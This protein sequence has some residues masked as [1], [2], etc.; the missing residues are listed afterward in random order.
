[1]ELSIIIVGWNVADLLSA[2]LESI[3]AHPPQAEYEIWV[4]DNASSDDTVKRVR[5]QFPQVK[6]IANAQNTGFA[7]AN[8]QAIELSQGK[9]ILLLN[10]D[11]IV[12]ERT[13]QSMLDFLESHPQAGAVGSIYFSPDGNLQKSCMP[14]P[15]VSRELW[16]LFHLDVLWS[17]GLYDMA[18]WS[19]TEPREVETLQGASLMLRRSAL[20]QAGLLD[21]D[22]FMYTEEVDLC[23]RL[24]K[25]GWKLYWLPESKITHY[26]GQST[27]QVAT[28]MFLNLY[29]SKILF[30]R[31]HYGEKKV[32]QYKRVLDFSSKIRLGILPVAAVLRPG[33]CEKYNEIHSNYAQL[34]KALP[35]L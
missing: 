6:L 25:L 17:Y 19:R 35:T 20:M 23:Y 31:K 34:I 28:R 22:Y 9:S 3:L 5:G 7:A 10:P 2:C 21:T 1:M 30:F 26:G 13:L 14:F 32:R 16:R 15:T 8:N 24:Y 18:R 33:Q 4:V 12:Y 27:R 11:T 29:G